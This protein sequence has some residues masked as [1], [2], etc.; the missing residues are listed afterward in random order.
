LCCLNVARCCVISVVEPSASERPISARLR[1]PGW[2]SAA[3]RRGTASSAILP[4]HARWRSCSTVQLYSAQLKCSFWVHVPTNAHQ[5]PRDRASV[6]YSVTETPSAMGS[7]IIGHAHAVVTV[8]SESAAREVYSVHSRA[9]VSCLLRMTPPGLFPSVSTCCT[10]KRQAA[11]QMVTSILAVPFWRSYASHNEPATSHNK[12]WPGEGPPS[13]SEG[14]WLHPSPCSA[15]RLS[16]H[17]LKIEL[18]DA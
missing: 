6:N 16:L 17:H 1:R 14:S 7:C 11:P 9:A 10:A 2:H 13:S 15:L 5:C 8:C 3:T 4:S 12:V 18:Q